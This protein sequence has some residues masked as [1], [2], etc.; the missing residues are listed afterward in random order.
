MF[1]GSKKSMSFGFG[2]LLALILM[3]LIIVILLIIFK[4]VA[5]GSEDQAMKSRC[6]SS[7]I[8]YARMRSLPNVPLTNRGMAD[9]STIFCPT[10]YVTVEP[11]TP[12]N[13]K[14][15][16]A[17]MMVECWDNYGRGELRLFG[18]TDNKYC[19]I[20]YVFEFEDRSTRLQ[21]L[22]SFMMSEKA[23]VFVDKKHPTY[24]EFI[25][26]QNAGP[27]AL[28][29]ARGI[30]INSFDGGRRYA[31]IYGLF[32]QSVWSTLSTSGKIFGATLGVMN[33]VSA[34]V[35]GGALFGPVTGIAAGG[36]VGGLIVGAFK[37]EANWVATLI[38]TEYDEEG[39]R[40][41]GCT[42]LPVSQLDERFR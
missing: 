22:P 32:T 20:C 24:Y 23:R 38:T 25:Y 41:L 18:A 5:Q 30:D 31:I 10:R 7:V 21:G 1:S 40:E 29:N 14:R 35:I 6:K 3:T 26:G 27:E 15:D 9:E 8:A 17:D 34:A 36:I 28:E 33:T 39:I 42:S 37:E 13:M 11:D 12:N 2:L 4:F 19:A 16:I